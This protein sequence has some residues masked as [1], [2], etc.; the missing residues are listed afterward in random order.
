MRAQ[1]AEVIATVRVWLELEQRLVVGVIGGVLAKRRAGGRGFGL[2]SQHGL[3]VSHFLHLL[4]EFRF[5]LDSV[6]ILG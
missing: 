6:K 1:R 5:R 3:G 2:R 4:E